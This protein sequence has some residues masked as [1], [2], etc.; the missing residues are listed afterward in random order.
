MRRQYD[1]VEHDLIDELRTAERQAR[2]A[3]A[4]LRESVKGDVGG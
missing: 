1:P 2:V 4:S 3:E